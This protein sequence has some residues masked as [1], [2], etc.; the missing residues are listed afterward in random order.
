MRME[1][2]AAGLIIVLTLSACGTRPGE[3]ALSGAGIGGAAGAIGTA[4]VGGPVLAG[5]AVG[6]AAGAITG[7]VSDP[8]RIRLD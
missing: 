4:I 3:R 2:I 6:A 1:H 8:N 5:A 7:A